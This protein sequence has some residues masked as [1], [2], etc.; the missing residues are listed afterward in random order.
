MKKIIST[1]ITAIFII[2]LSNVYVFATTTPT[3]S[4]TT[5]TATT[6]YNVGVSYQSHVHNIGWQDSWSSD[7]DTSGT[8]GQSLPMEALKIKLVNAPAGAK[9]NYQAHVQNIGWINQWQSNGDTAGTTGRG[10]NLEAIKI[11]LEGLPG[12]TIQ[13]QA[14]VKNIG[15]QDFVSDGQ[16]AGTTGQSLDIEA[17]RIKIVP[18]IH[19]S[20]INLNENSLS[21]GIGQNAS[22]HPIVLPTNA[23]NKSV[24]WT[25]S[26]K[27]IAVVDQAGKVIGLNKGNTTIIATTKD[28]N[29]IA[30]CTVSVKYIPVTDITLNKSSSTIYAG[31]SEPLSPNIAP[32]NASNK[33]I[34][35]TSSDSSVATVDSSGTVTGLKAGNATITATS[36]DGNKTASCNYIVNE[37]NPSVTCQGQVQDAGWQNPTNDS[38]IIGTTGMNLRLESIKIN[39]NDAPAGARIKYQAFVQNIGWQNVNYDGSIAGTVGQGLRIEAIRISLEN[40]PGYSVA[41][42][43]HVQNIGWVPWGI[44]GEDIGTTD[45]SLRIEAL[46]VKIIKSIGVSYQTH[47][48]NIGWQS[49]VSNG[50]ISDTNGQSLRIEA[51]NAHLINAPAGAS[52]EYKAQVQNIGWQDYVTDGATA[53]TT[54]QGLAIESISMNLKNLPG[55]N[56]QYQVFVEN[57]GWQSWCENGQVAGTVGKGLKIKGLRIRVVSN[58]EADKLPDVNQTQLSYNISNYLNSNDNI[59]SVLTRAIQ[60]HDGNTSN[61]C[62]FFSSEVL[63][64][65]GYNVPIYMANTAT[66]VPYLFNR[67]WKA[68]YSVDELAVGDICFTVNDSSGHPTH[69]FVFMGW[70]NPNNHNMA[71]VVD[72]Q[73]HYIHIRSMVQT[74]D[75]D[76][77]AFCVRN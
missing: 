63:R 47:V 4:T 10:L 17:I 12:Y 21:L 51:L 75:Y 6:T 64:R 57:L 25:T 74:S 1:I 22:L 36:A 56:I 38:G 43:A 70:V 44:D 50:A 66:Y 40:M 69:T 60:L 28:G 9:I 26:D 20:E 58:L 15:W 77:F 49:P 62:V 61:N 48:Q 16:I 2:N 30:T 23:T 35:W 32:E 53:G 8:T 14:H 55:Y 45:R 72:N 13:Y 18:I 54:G 3:I 52:I 31:E 41:Y 76:Q 46:Q 39:L 42:R 27:N 19:P 67:G 37:H 34:N 68:Y 73:S 24:T 29:D 5:P 65:L 7:G 71:Y 59:N 33:A 11:T